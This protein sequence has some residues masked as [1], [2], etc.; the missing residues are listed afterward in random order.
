VYRNT[1][2]CYLH[3]ALLP[4]NPQ[5]A[6]H[7]IAVALQRRYG[8][9]SALVPLDDALELAAQQVMVERMLLRD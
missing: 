6:D 4:K 9:A 2:G 3:G 5:L 8:D 7:L 1:I